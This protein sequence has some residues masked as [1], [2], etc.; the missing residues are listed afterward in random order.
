MVSLLELRLAFRAHL[1]PWP[2]T[3]VQ[4]MAAQAQRVVGEDRL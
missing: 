4:C 2:M 1:C 3:L